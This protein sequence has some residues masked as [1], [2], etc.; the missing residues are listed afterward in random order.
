MTSPPYGTH[1]HALKKKQNKNNKKTKNHKI[2]EPQRS[3]I[4]YHI[5]EEQTGFNVVT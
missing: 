4:S 3:L 1:D 2:L 5:T